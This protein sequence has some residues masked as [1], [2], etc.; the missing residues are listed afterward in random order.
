MGSHGDSGWYPCRVGSGGRAR[1]YCHPR[2]R[3]PPTTG[4]FVGL[5]AGC[6]SLAGIC[7]GPGALVI[8]SVVSDTFSPGGQDFVADVTFNAPLTTLLGAPLGTLHT[9]GTLAV[10]LT[11]RTSPNDTGSW[12]AEIDFLDLGGTLFGA[13]IDIGVEHEQHIRGHRQHHSGRAGIPHP[14]L[15]RRVRGA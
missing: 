10:G 12:S 3:F 2:Y 7:S 1:G 5:G 4:V 15:L 14:Q 11:G 13:P 6:F 9:T 8:Q